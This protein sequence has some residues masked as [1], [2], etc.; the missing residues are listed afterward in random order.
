MSA[1]LRDWLKAMHMMSC[2]VVFGAR[3]SPF[4]VPSADHSIRIRLTFSHL[5]N[6][7]SAATTDKGGFLFLCF[8]CFC[9]C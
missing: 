5:S 1:C 4:G 7:F 8:I 6:L 9:F 3:F 2:D